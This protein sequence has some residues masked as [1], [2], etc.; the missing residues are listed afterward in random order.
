M[1]MDSLA[2]SD[3]RSQYDFVNSQAGIEVEDLEPSPHNSSYYNFGE[4]TEGGP[5]TRRMLLQ[6]TEEEEAPPTSRGPAARP[7]QS[8]VNL[9]ANSDR[10][11]DDIAP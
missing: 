5:P 4:P 3:S 8:A 11:W 10:F 9:T 7:K 1:V 6:T 2:D